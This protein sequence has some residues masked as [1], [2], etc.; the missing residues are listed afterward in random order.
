MAETNHR[1]PQT[2][3]ICMLITRD[4]NAAREKRDQRTAREKRNERGGRRDPLSG[5]ET[6]TLR[7][8]TGQ[9]NLRCREKSAKDRAHCSDGVLRQVLVDKRPAAK[10]PQ[11]GKVQLQSPLERPFRRANHGRQ[12]ASPVNFDLCEKLGVRHT[13]RGQWA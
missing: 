6:S 1:V 2:P 8:A 5:P 12:G 9:I 11:S 3:S 13:K 7:E 4:R 10:E